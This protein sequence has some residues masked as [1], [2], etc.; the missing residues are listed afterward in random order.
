MKQI[1]LENGKVIEVDDDT[2]YYISE[3]GILMV[4]VPNGYGYGYA[5]MGKVK[6]IK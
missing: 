1:I 2:P 5:P 6:E 4:Y 3:G